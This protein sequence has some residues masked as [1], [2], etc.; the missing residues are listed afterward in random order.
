M[1]DFGK[2][3]GFGR[4]CLGV[5]TASP[6]NYVKEAARAPDEGPLQR[7]FIRVPHGRLRAAPFRTRTAAYMGA[8]PRSRA[9][10]RSPRRLVSR[11]QRLKPMAPSRLRAGSAKRPAQRSR[12][13]ATLASWPPAGRRPN[14]NLPRPH[15]HCPAILTAASIFK[16]RR[17]SIA[18]R[19]RALSTSSGKS[20]SPC[21]RVC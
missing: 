15:T 21:L 6:R 12:S 5:Q 7:R 8:A 9:G 1:S 18:F 16:D 4:L 14:S 20:T 13:G 17:L 19:R 11:R 3:A 10:A 2:Q